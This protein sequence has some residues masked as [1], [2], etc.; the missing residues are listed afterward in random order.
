MLRHEGSWLSR[1]E[2]VGV[3]VVWLRYVCWREEGL[4]EPVFGNE[5]LGHCEEELSPYFSDGVYTPVSGFIEGLVCRGVDCRVGRVW[6]VSDSS[7][8]VG[9][10]CAHGVDIGSVPVIRICPR[11]SEGNLLE[12]VMLLNLPDQGGDG[13]SPSFT[14][15]SSLAESETSRIGWT[16]SK[17]GRETVTAC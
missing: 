15:T 3:V 1:I 8:V 7:D 16:T 5:V 17:S 6:E 13:I 9:S 12:L 2:S 10:P 4:G 14:H 11:K